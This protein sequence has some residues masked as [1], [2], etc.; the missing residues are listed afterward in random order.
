MIVLHSKKFLF[1]HMLKTGGTSVGKALLPFVQEGDEAYGYTK[2]YEEVSFENF[3]KMRETGQA[4]PHKHSKGRE[5][6]DIYGD[7]ID[8]YAIVMTIRNT[9]SRVASWFHFCKAR[10]EA[11]V[12]EGK[13]KNP[14]SWA[15][16]HKDL[17]AFVLS[18]NFFS[19]PISDF[20]DRED[21]TPVVTHHLD[22]GD[23]DGLNQ[24]IRELIGEDSFAIGHEN[25]VRFKGYGEEK[26]DFR[27]F[28]SNAAAAKVGE[29]FADEIKRFDFQFDAA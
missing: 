10:N 16:Q 20:S 6:H 4:Y 8:D 14:W 15:G 23:N 17:S 25:R 24:S 29:V 22:I 7:K 18:E 28:Y 21:G 3:T 19:S 12:A 9:W 5:L 27:S 11:F 13:I 1:V 26:S 2:Q